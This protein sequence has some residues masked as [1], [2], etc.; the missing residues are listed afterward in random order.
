ME[1]KQSI[2]N[3]PILPDEIEWKVQSYTKGD[4]KKTIIVPYITSR[5]V[6]ERFDAE[7]GVMGWQTTFREVKDGFICH[8]SVKQDTDWISKEDGASRTSIEPI[9]GG[10]SD[11]LKRAAHQFGLGRCL[12]SYP[13]IMIKGEIKYISED[14]IKELNKMVVQINSGSFNEKV[15]VLSQGVQPQPE[16]LGNRENIKIKELTT[17]DVEKWNGKIYGK[18]EVYIDGVKHRVSDDQLDKLKELDKYQPEKK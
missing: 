3:K 6:M 17:S 18:D 1:P 5:C 14:I 4:N 11:S 7:F 10:I 12:Y 16:S 2:I 8:L 15:V 9:K 13:R